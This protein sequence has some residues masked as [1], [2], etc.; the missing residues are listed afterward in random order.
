MK[1]I[2]NLDKNRRYNDPGVYCEL[3]FNTFFPI[4]EWYYMNQNHWYNLSVIWKLLFLNK[5]HE[6]YGTILHK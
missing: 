5:K 2:N 1:A 4:Y 3:A 6:K